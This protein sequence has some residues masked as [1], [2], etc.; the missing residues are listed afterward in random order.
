MAAHEK[1]L[2]LYVG[3]YLADT[4]HLTTAQHG[5]YLLLIMH[6]WRSGGRIPAEAAQQAAVARMTPEQWSIDGPAV[7]AFFNDDLTHKRVV[8]ELSVATKVVAQR[9]LAGKAS[10]AKRERKRQRDFNGE[11]TGPQREANGAVDAPLPSRGTPSPSPSVSKDTGG[12]LAAV[13]FKG[14]LTWMVERTGKPEASCRAQLGKWRKEIGDASLIEVLGAAQREGPI[15]AMAWLEK[16]VAARSGAAPRKPWEKPPA[17]DLPPDEPWE[18]RMAGWTRTKFWMPTNWGPPPGQ[19][20][21]RVP[22]QFLDPSPR[23]SATEA[24]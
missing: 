23:Y 5:A 10:A 12:D 11:A 4:M 17:R 9:S 16:A 3:D 2:P 24:A 13:I 8:E 1:W 20:G 6:A 15:D 14:G 19:P 18:Q 21:C 7:L 22:T